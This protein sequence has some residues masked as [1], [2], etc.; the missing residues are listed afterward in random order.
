MERNWEG[1]IFYTLFFIPIWFA[2]TWKTKK[3][4]FTAKRE[5]KKHKPENRKSVW[6]RNWLC[7]PYADVES[8]YNIQGWNMRTYRDEKK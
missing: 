3:S 4:E 5:K 1:C 6:I 8:V 2:P 7:E